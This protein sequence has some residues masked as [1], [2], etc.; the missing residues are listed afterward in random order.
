MYIKYNNF[1]LTIKFEPTSQLSDLCILTCLM[2]TDIIKTLVTGKFFSECFLCK[3]D[4]G[5]SVGI[6]GCTETGPSLDQ[7][8]EVG[9]GRLRAA[10][11][12]DS[13]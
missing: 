10:S 3:F 9:M 11:E 7:R 2:T 5:R 8:V 4:I 13:G 12:D 6:T 1:K